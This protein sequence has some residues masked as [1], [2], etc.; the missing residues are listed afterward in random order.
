MRARPAWGGVVAKASGTVEYDGEMIEIQEGRD[1]VARGHALLKIA[2]HLFGLARAEPRA[3]RTRSASLAPKAR[4]RK[5]IELRTSVESPISVVLDESARRVIV[6]EVSGWSSDSYGYGG[7]ETGGYLF[8]RRSTCGVELTFAAYAGEETKRGYGNVQLDVYKGRSVERA[9]QEQRT[10]ERLVGDYHSHPNS[11]GVPSPADLRAWMRSVEM[12][13][14]DDPP[15]TWF[16][17]NEIASDC[18]TGIIVTRSTGGDWLYAQ[19]HGW[20]VRWEY[21]GF[22]CEPAAIHEM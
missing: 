19:L 17:G 2:P 21:A 1:H 6:E 11:D 5:E 3:E 15:P 12:L 18:W 9:L 16:V 4:A 20:V 22:I 8:G 10:R 13:L 7:L 14:S